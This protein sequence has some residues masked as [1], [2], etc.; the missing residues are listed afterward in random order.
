[1]IEALKVWSDECFW[2]KVE[3]AEL[4]LRPFCDASFLLQRENNTLADVVLVLLHL[5]THVQDFTGDCEDARKVLADMR[6]RWDDT[7]QPL[8]IIAFLL[9]PFYRNTATEMIKQAQARNGSWPSTTNKF[10]ARRIA[11]AAKFYYIK[12]ALSSF[13]KDSKDYKEELLRVEVSMFQW[14]NG[15]GNFEFQLFP[16]TQDLYPA[17]ADWFKSN[18][19]V[20]GVPFTRFAIY[21]LNAPI[22]SASCERLFKDFSRYHTKTRNRLSREKMLKSTHIKYDLKEKYPSQ[23]DASTTRRKSNAAWDNAH[24]NRFIAPEEHPRIEGHGENNHSTSV[25]VSTEAEAHIA[26]EDD[27]E[28]Q[29]IDVDVAAL[30]ELYDDGA[31]GH[32]VENNELRAILASLRSA[33]PSEDEVYEEGTST[34]DLLL[35]DTAMDGPDDDD[36][37]ELDFET[38]LQRTRQGMQN[39]EEDPPEYQSKEVPLPPIPLDNPNNY[40]QENPAYFCG[41]K[42]VRND[43]YPLEDMMFP[44]LRLPSIQSTYTH[45]GLQ[46]DI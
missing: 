16:Y 41:K 39:R 14:I 20:L 1:M 19:S 30:A 46:H 15:E 38:M 2:F 12:A 33:L 3:E 34:D 9:H 40:P 45:R 7:E 22:Q 28:E 37:R 26:L 17:V 42:Y 18:E 43:K 29:G 8:Y 27:D 35:K 23:Q 4:L 11:H 36:G 24:R 10:C 21:V 44:G 31:I 25:I 6:R 13:E 32:D 5:V